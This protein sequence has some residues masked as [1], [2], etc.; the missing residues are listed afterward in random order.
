MRLVENIS[1]SFW[2]KRPSCLQICFYF[3][4][5]LACILPFSNVNG[6]QLTFSNNKS[7]KAF[8]T[9]KRYLDRSNYRQAIISL[10]EVL[11]HDSLFV[12]A[13]Q[14]LGDLYLR[15]R[16]Y[17]NALR[18]YENVSRLAPNLTVSTWFG[19]G[20][21][22]LN[23]G[24]YEKAKDALLIYLTK[25]KTQAITKK[26]QAEKYIKDCEFSI[27]ALK[28][29][30]EIE[31]INMGESI[32]S[33]EDEYFP[34]LTA[35]K[36][37]ILF[38]RQASGKLE[39]IF[40]SENHHS[41]WDLA[42]PIPG[43]VNTDSYSEGAH[44]I[45]P[46]GK[47]LFFTGCNKTEGKGSCD[48]Y[49]SY[50]EGDQWGTPH[51]LGTP[52]NTSVWEAQPAISSDGNKLYFVSNRKGG[53]GGN[54]IWCSTLTDDGKWSAPVNLGPQVN[55]PYDEGTPF[56]HADQETLY[57][58]SNGWPGFGNKDLF[59]SK[60][61]SS[62]NRMTPINLGSPINNHLEQRA[63]TVSMD[64][65]EAFFASASSD[66]FGGLDIYTFRLPSNIRPKSVGFVKGKVYNKKTG[67]ALKAEISLTD[68][69]TN[70]VVFKTIADYIDGTF[71]AP[72]PLAKQYALHVSHPSFLFYTQHFTL[73]DTLSKKDFYQLDI[74]LTAIDPGSSATLNNIFFP[75]NGYNLLP[76]SGA[77]LMELANFMKIN[78]KVRIE[79]SG[80]TDNT[81]KEKDNQFLSEKRALAVY[82][83]LLSKQIEQ[84]RMEYKGYGQNKPIADNSTE[85]GRRKNRRT[86]F[87]I[88]A[89]D[90]VKQ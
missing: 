80:H 83:Y 59:V 54:D 67:K 1:S 66:S 31:I 7:K 12:T 30:K 10:E 47:Y 11:T 60:L 77:D 55:T 87:K 41:K 61:D 45:S 65:R 26:T 70:E 22:A 16:D 88:L 38:T 90:Y 46:D 52:I 64:G 53:Y 34:M 8:E 2:P 36:S 37:S 28:D 76:I 33:A 73:Q 49:V 18:H 63:L 74:P 56:I 62:K 82:N 13:H 51:N 86:D 72:L 42:V 9:A 14:Q 68:L 3:I 35:D 81:G 84:E 19:L 17:S 21:S 15:Q 4:F 39:Y 57:F 24:K 69:H 79:I 25:G 20:E 58:S 50:L 23:L 32:N 85:E 78:K 71:L 89:I 40:M 6:Q 27:N 43:N 44:C 5:V 29:T 48:I 75:I